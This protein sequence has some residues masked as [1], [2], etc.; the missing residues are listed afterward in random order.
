MKIDL[1]YKRALVG[2]ASSGLGKAIALELANCGAHVTLVSHHE[3]KIAETLSQLSTEYKQEHSFLVV[4]YNDFESYKK[5]MA[6]YLKHNP[7]DIL[8][9]NTQGPEAG[10]IYEKKIEDYQA[11]FDLLFKVNCFTSLEAIKGMAKRHW[12]RIINVSSMTVKEPNENLILSN[13]IR[14]AWQ[15]WCKSLSDAYA[16]KG[17]TVNTILTGLFET[18]R[19][20]KLTQIAADKQKISLENALMQRLADIPMKRLGKPEEYG[21]LAAFLASDQAAYLTGASIP[22][23]GGM[24]KSLA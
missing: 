22:L 1:R 13:T 9:N 3:N 11:A 4:D 16:L 10:S 24:M 17:I 18:D 23:N 7:I 2:G 15:S 21:Y 19:I 20:I 8:V 14:V 6:N 12:G 5:I